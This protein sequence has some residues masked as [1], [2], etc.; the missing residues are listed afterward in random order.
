MKISAVVLTK[1]SADKIK[2]LYTSLKGFDEIIFIDDGST[3]KTKALCSKFG[4]TYIKRALKDDF[5]SQRNHAMDIAKYDWVFFLD[6][7][8]KVNSI[9]TNEVRENI[10]IGGYNGYYIKRINI[11]FDHKVMGTEMG[12]QHI[13]RLANKSYGR[14]KRKVHEYWDVKKPLGEISES[15]VHTT[16]NSITEFINKIIMYYVIHAEENMGS[17]KKSN[18]Y[19]VIL[20]PLLKCI[21]N[22]IFLNGYKDGVYGFVISVLMSF[23]SYL[24]WSQMWLKSRR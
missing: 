22:F 19:K 6:S 3:D 16:A 14:W 7:D 20:F 5:S 9:F 4:I 23:H 2:S 10:K 21:K 12:E 11:F 24:S 8:E 15:V 1:N 17:G 13:I 18:F